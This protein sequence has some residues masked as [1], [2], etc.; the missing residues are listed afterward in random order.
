MLKVYIDA[1]TKGN[2]GPIEIEKQEKYQGQ[3]ELSNKDLCFL[4][5]ESD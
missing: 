1:S 2:P 5:K 3:N 4:K